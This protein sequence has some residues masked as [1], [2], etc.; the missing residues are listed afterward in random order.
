MSL[1]DNDMYDYA[2]TPAKEPGRNV[3]R[4][5]IQTT[6]VDE[7]GLPGIMPDEEW[8]KALAAATRDWND[9]L[10]PMNP[11]DLGQPVSIPTVWMKPQGFP[12]V[13]SQETE[14][15]SA[16]QLTFKI[17]MTP[18][19]EAR[20]EQA[21]EDLRLAQEILDTAKQMRRATILFFIFGGIIAAVGVIMACLSGMGLLS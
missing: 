6:H 17:S 21:K 8:Q 7:N 16:E 15:P 12:G 4:D 3:Y 11:M 10:A 9:G 19:L 1:L 18:D 20:F 14:M 13:W 5:P 2:A